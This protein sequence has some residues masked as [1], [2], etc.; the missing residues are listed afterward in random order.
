MRLDGQVMPGGG[1]GS[2]G[3]LTAGRQ[4]AP[5]ERAPHVLGAQNADLHGCF[6]AR[7]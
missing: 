1:P 6:K 7:N 2:E 5:G 4:P 3:D